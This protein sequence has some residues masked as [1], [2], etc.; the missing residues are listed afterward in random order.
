MHWRTRRGC[1]KKSWRQSAPSIASRVSLWFEPRR[2]ENKSAQGNA[3]GTFS[4]RMQALV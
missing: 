2:G 1:G 3:L 4:D